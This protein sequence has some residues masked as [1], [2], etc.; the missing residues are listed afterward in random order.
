MQPDSSHS[1]DENDTQQM[2][3]VEINDWVQICLTNHS[4]YVVWLASA[5][6]CK[7]IDADEYRLLLEHH[8]AFIARVK[9]YARKIGRL[10]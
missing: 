10:K 2:P 4:S 9:A 5:Y 8:E 1:F 6:A 3:A 7:A